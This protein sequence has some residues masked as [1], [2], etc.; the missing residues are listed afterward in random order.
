MHLTNLYA[1]CMS[2]SKA[3]NTQLTQTLV[4]GVVSSRAGAC[5]SFDGSFGTSM[6]ARGRRYYMKTV[7]SSK[8][9]KWGPKAS[10]LQS[11]KSKSGL[12]SACRRMTAGICEEI[13]R[14]KITSHCLRTRMT[15]GAVERTGSMH[16]YR[17]EC[18]RWQKLG[19]GEEAQ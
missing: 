7:V 14:H 19:D 13:S 12:N 15:P 18:S 17:R 8:A 5:V 6:T 10:P 4:L 3:K 9:S 16:H 2:A 11:H 1:S